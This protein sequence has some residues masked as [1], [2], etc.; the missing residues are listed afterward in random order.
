MSHVSLTQ[1]KSQVKLKLNETIKRFESLTE[2]NS[3]HSSSMRHKKKV[4][5]IIN[6]NNIVY[7]TVS[8]WFCKRL[9]FA[10]L[11]RISEESPL[12]M[13]RAIEFNDRIQFNKRILTFKHCNTKWIIK[14]Q[15]YNR[16]CSENMYSWTVCCSFEQV[17]TVASV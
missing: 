7:K 6:A 13:K 11:N 15:D 14:S 3:F 9:L 8:T 17:A 4:N 12:T 16:R 1:P 5:N 2:S 10:L